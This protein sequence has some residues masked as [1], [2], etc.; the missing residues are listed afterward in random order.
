MSK[1]L[2]CFVVLACLCTLLE[3]A[4]SKSVVERQVYEDLI[5]EKNVRNKRAVDVVTGVKNAV[6]G[7]VFNKLNSFIDQKTHW[8]A[9]LDKQNIAKNEAA[10]IVPPADPVTSLS[11][12]ISG[13]IGQKLQ[14]SA[15]LLNIVTSKLGGLSSGGGGFNIGALLTK[16]LGSSSSGSSGGAHNKADA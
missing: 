6:L 3:L 2:W 12:V 11:S 16:G 8:I 15:P 14:A 13:A 4:E 7:F 1:L 5:Q 9:E 10:N